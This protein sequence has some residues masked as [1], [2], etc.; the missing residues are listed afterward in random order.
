MALMTF[1]TFCTKSWTILNKE[2][3]LLSWSNF[4]SAK[5]VQLLLLYQVRRPKLKSSS[6]SPSPSA[7]PDGIC[8]HGL[9]FVGVGT[10]I[11]QEDYREPLKLL[12]RPKQLYSM[13]TYIPILMQETNHEIAYR[14]GAIVGAPSVA[15]GC[16]CV[17]I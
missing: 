14:T 4:A 17:S 7:V 13:A 15:I 5:H 9:V 8:P 10:R 12:P 16:H 6:T 1:I 3:T 2:N 11:V